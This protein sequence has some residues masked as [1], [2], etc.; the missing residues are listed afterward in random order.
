MDRPARLLRRGLTLLASVSACAALLAPAVG[1]APSS[2]RNECVEAGTAPLPAL[3][4][5][6]FIENRSGF[7]NPR[8][9]IRWRSG[10]MP[11][12]C[13]GHLR[14]SVAV[15]VRLRTSNGH[16]A[17]TIGR[18]H[19]ELNWL[20]FIEG[21]KPE[22]SGRAGAVGMVFSRPLGCIRRVIGL[23]RYEV[24]DPKGHLLGRRVAP[25]EPRFQPC[26]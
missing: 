7:S 26:R 17:I 3:S 5:R 24:S 16:A 10:Q 2:P 8:L 1:A 9:A 4:G 18:G 19:R 14:R 22:P 23:V 11:A 12:G 21:F 6:A 20:T 15:A 13:E 25:F